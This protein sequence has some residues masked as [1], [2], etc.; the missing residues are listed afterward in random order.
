MWHSKSIEECLESVVEV[1]PVD[2][3]SRLLSPEEDD[4]E[5]TRKLMGPMNNRNEAEAAQPDDKEESL[6]RSGYRDLAT[7]KKPL[8]ERVTLGF[9]ELWRLR[10]QRLELRVEGRADPLFVPR[11]AVRMA[12]AHGS[13]ERSPFH[14]TA[15]CLPNDSTDQRGQSVT[16]ELAAD[17][18]RPRS[19][20]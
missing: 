11:A 16:F 20:E 7:A 2:N 6:E 19:V 14:V 1:A 18:T 3:R 4:V 10:T 17:A 8:W 5:A 13:E 12:R 15:P 9:V